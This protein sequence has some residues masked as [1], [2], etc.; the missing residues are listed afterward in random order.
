MRCQKCQM[1]VGNEGMDGPTGGFQCYK[2]AAESYRNVAAGK[3]PASTPAIPTKNPD[4]EKPVAISVSTAPPH[5]SFFPNKA[6]VR[7]TPVVMPLPNTPPRKTANETDDGEGQQRCN[8]LSWPES[9]G[10]Q[11][12]FSLVESDTGKFADVRWFRRSEKYDGP[13]KQGI[14]FGMSDL[15]NVVQS[16]SEI[17]P[18]I[19]G[20]TFSKEQEFN[21]IQRGSSTQIVLQVVPDASNDGSW[22]FDMRIYV[23]TAKYTGF[24]PKGIRVRI[25]QA[26]TLL[27]GLKELLAR[28][29]A[30]A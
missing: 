26:S 6:S 24:T 7:P 12:V 3:L 2:C 11:L 30:W 17:V 4:K 23:D 1:E 21:R 27:S 20:A 25:D 22:D 29:Q 15:Q 9:N 10:R 8:V 14:R 19:T 28:Y 5:P 13:T 18:R 16:V